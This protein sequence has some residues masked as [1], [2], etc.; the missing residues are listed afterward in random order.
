MTCLICRR[1][2]IV[3]GLTSIALA[4]GEFHLMVNRVP[5]RVC[6]LCGEAYLEE[7]ITVQLLSLARQWQAAGMSDLQC[8]YSPL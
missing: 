8:E 1:A 3:D 5:A 2:E 4:R 6:P 7:A